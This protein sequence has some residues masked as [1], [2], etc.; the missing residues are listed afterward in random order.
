MQHYSDYLREQ[1]AK[2]RELA[3]TAGELFVKQE[4]PELAAICE[5]VASNI[6]DRRVSG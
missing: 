4:F 1:A 2:Y 6:D 5:E 3:E